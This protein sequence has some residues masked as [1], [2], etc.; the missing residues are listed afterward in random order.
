V[1]GEP[2][3]LPRWAEP[4]LAALPALV[5]AGGGLAHPQFLTPATADRWFVAHL[6]LLPVFPLLGVAVVWLLRGVPGPYA[7]VARLLAYAYAV[8]YTAL[9]AIAG[10]GAGWLVGR[11]ADRG[12]PG[13]DLG[14]TFLIGDRIGRPG[15]VCLGAAGLF[16]ALALQAGNR[17]QASLGGVLVAAGSVLVWKHHVFWPEGVLGMLVIGGGL[18]LA[19]HGRERVGLG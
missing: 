7:V 14:E 5:L 11:A 18:A 16:L 3:R 10:I 19:A 12:R 2:S 13:P 8:L 17:L 15:A 4:L 6:V 9:D 1:S